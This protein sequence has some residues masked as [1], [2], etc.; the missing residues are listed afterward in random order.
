MIFEMSPVISVGKYN[1]H[2]E[3]SDDEGKQI[4]EYRQYNKDE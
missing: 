1:G 4:T 2:D 3:G